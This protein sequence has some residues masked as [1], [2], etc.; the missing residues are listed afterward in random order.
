MARGKKLTKEIVGNILTINE[1]SLPKEMKFDFAALPLEIQAK[2]GP[3]GYASKLGDAAAG[4][5]G[6]EAVD[7]IMKVQE[8]LAKGDWSVRAPAGEKVSKKGIMEKYAALSDKE[9]KVA[10]PLLR[11]LGLL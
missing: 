9:K 2:L 10:E 3:F 11:Q 4:K 1:L 6:Q 8:G 7:A 5:E